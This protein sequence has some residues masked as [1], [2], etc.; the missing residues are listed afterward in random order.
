MAI[1]QREIDVLQGIVGSPIAVHA[2]PALASA[3]GPAIVLL[4]AAAAA[5]AFGF[6]PLVPL[7]E[8]LTSMWRA[9]LAAPV[10]SEVLP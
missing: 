1:A 8:S 4:S 7:A 6:R 2:D 3:K 5:A 9:A 10:R